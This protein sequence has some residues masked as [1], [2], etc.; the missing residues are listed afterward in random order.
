MT[1]Q[2]RPITFAE[3]GQ[4]FMEQAFG[5]DVIKQ[6]MDVVV[7]KEQRISTGGPSPV[8]VV[9][10]IALGDVLPSPTE[11]PSQELRYEVPVAVRMSLSVGLLLAQEQYEAAASTRLRL[12]IRTYMPLMVYVEVEPLSADE[13]A[14]A[15]EGQGNWLDLVKRVGVL[16]TVIR[17]QLA[18]AIN[19]QLEANQSERMID[20]IKTMGEMMPQ[21]FDQMAQQAS[22]AQSEQADAL[23]PDERAA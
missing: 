5:P 6:A 7:P 21:M 22:Q 23:S 3:F 12:V 15:T 2:T 20:M 17:Q 16:D 10:Q 4:R 14:V 8:E 13:I 18:S 19:E 1:E 11:V 9:A